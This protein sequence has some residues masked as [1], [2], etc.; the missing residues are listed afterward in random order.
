DVRFVNTGDLNVAG[1]DQSGGDLFVTSGSDLAI[2]GVNVTVGNVVVATAGDLTIS[3]A[4]TTFGNVR[5]TAGGAIVQIDEG[6]VDGA[7]L[8][9]T[10]SGGGQSLAGENRVR[11]FEVE[12]VEGDLH[13]VNAGHLEITGIAQTAGNV[14]VATAG[15]LTI[16]GAVTTAGEVHFEAA[17]ANVQ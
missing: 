7:V 2:S 16:S 10:A 12:R 6:R 5:L 1:V 8:L 3:G 13:L 17:G 11:T 15:D 9:S 14:V 4:V